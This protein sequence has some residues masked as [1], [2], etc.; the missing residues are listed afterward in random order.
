MSEHNHNHHHDHDHTSI[1]QQEA[2][3]ADHQNQMD[4]SMTHEQN[5]MH[6]MM[7][8]VFHFGSSETILFGFWRISSVFGLLF[9]LAL[10]V[11]S[12]FLLEFVRWYRLFRKKEQAT[13]ALSSRRRQTIQERLNPN[14][15]LDVVLHIVQLT[16]SYF[17]M[18]IVMTFNVWLCMGVV[19]GE[20]LARSI[21]H[22]FFPHLDLISQ[23]LATADENCCG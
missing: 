5:S 20:A 3:S 18:L 22:L 7:N 17:L 19:I 8:M 2:P 10:I 15:A 12:C 9:S 14:L 13:E 1:E 23:T 16:L 4:L 6:S 11:A 21:I